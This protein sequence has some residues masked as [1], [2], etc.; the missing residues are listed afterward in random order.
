MARLESLITIDDM[1]EPAH[2]ALAR[3]LFDF[4]DGGAGDVAV[5]TIK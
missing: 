2:R 1:R 5:R 4:V 3:M